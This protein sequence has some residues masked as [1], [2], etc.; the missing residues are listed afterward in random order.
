[1]SDPSGNAAITSNAGDEHPWL[2]EDR[3]EAG[4]R[5]AAALDRYRAKRPLVLGLPRG[6]V[7]IAAEIAIALGAPLDVM[8]VRK[9][10]APSHRELGIGAIASGGILVLDDAIVG[11]LRI[12]ADELSRIAAEELRELDRQRLKFRGDRPPLD[13]HEQTVILA[14][15]GLATGVSAAAA[16][17]AARTLG[18]R[19]VILAVPVGAPE[20]VAALQ[21]QVDEL[22]CLA[23]PANFHAV[24]L[25]YRDF[26]QTTDES[27]IRLL[28]EARMRAGATGR[29]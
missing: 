1:M 20:S 15:D 29:E 11:E 25:W 13:L 3:R 18:A 5:L 10:G 28:E 9:L 16:S 2:F 8:P 4:R 22:V 24:G 6:G 21:S 19:W 12:Q 26:E 14:D 17:K 27:V 23:S 7:P